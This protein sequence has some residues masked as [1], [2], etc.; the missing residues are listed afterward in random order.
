MARHLGDVVSK[1]QERGELRR[2][3]I[4]LSIHR[5][6]LIHY[7]NTC[8]KTMKCQDCRAKSSLSAG[9]DKI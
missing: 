2:P 9:N 3:E 7:V 4:L 6:Y 1:L 8:S 5:G